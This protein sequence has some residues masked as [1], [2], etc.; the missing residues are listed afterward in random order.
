MKAP[1]TQWWV[2]QANLDSIVCS[3]GRPQL[4]KTGLSPRLEVGVAA[5]R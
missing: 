5:R 2:D 4:E 3:Y 1:Q